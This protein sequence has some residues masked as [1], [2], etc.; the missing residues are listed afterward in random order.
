MQYGGLVRF[1]RRTGQGLGIQPQPGKGEPPLRWNWDSPLLISPH[2]NTRLYFAANK[3]FRSDDRGDSWKAVSGDL[4][5]QLNRDQLPILGKIQ[6]ADA[7]AKHLSTSYYGN[8]TAL[9][10]S[11]KREGLLYAG[12]DD[13]LI[14]VTEDGGGS[15][16]R[17]EKFPEI[18]ER[19]YVSRILASQHEAGTVY[20]AFD[21]HKMSDFA[22][23][24]LKSTDA[25][26]TWAS[27]RG[28]LPM[29]GSVL[30]VA[31]DH[32]DP[33]LLF[34]GTEFGLYVTLDGGKKWVRLKGGLP[35]IAVRDLAV[36]RQMDDLV[37]GTFGRGIYIL[38]DYSPLRGSKPELL[39]QEAALFPVKDA[40]L[41]IPT[42][43]YGLRGKAFL[44]E[45]FYAAANPPFGATF[46]YHLKD[47]IKTKKQLRHEAEKEAE[48]KKEPPPLP[49][50][51]QLRAEAEEEAPTILLTISDATGRALRTLTGP[52]SKGFHRVAWDLRLPAP[53]LPRPRLTEA[54]ED[55]FTD[56]PSGPLVLPGSYRV[57]LARRVGGV[58]TPLG[59]AQEFAVVVEGSDRLSATDRQALSE[60]QQKVARLDRAVSGALEAANDLN[61][62][63][64]QI[65]RALD[66]TPNIE[67]K[68]QD[69]VRAL[70]QRNRDILRALRGD[71]A[72]RARNE[73]TPESIAERVRYAVNAQRF[74]LTPPTKTQQESYQ[75]A[76]EEF[77]Q[78]LAKLR[79]LIDVDLRDLEK[80]L[81]A[82]GAPVTP[83]RLP[84]W[85]GK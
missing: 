62:R 38:D 3:V 10:E 26:K 6:T 69:A 46:T 73:N 43:Q 5:R 34:A 67:A 65:R 39:K 48:K 19:T 44:G 17:V 11:P 77:T 51:E 22:P 16:R 25:G 50:R 15:W 32:K 28:D 59:G 76:S 68:W 56:E 52:V 8:I 36:Q 55:L 18:P 53:A 57:S 83:G 31:E 30:A 72:L 20:A 58:V 37:V 35:T 7:V 75:I 9:A 33:N 81:D 12:T 64:A 27:I 42:R 78:E 29:R 24:L 70:E 21:N 66:Q 71:V 79:T 4:T 82:A 40:L 2:S 13:G 1:D 85:K 14:Q 41:Y 47:E 61:N 54:A 80:A 84:D 45:S 60:F 49:T 63:L 23:Y 74:A